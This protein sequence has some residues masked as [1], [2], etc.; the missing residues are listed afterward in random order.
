M[1][2]DVFTAGIFAMVPLTI[3]WA[4]WAVKLDCINVCVILVVFHSRGTIHKFRHVSIIHVVIHSL[5]VAAAT[6]STRG[7][8][9]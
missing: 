5:V 7:C 1:R 8:N 2:A 6:T 9:K 3:V 4:D